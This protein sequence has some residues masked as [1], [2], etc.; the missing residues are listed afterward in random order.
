MMLRLQGNRISKI[1]KE[2]VTHSPGIRYLYLGENE[3]ASLER[4]AMAQFE[5]VQVLDLSYNRLSEVTTDTFS[6]LAHLLHL[7]LEGNVIKDVAPGAFSQTPLLLLWLASNCLSDVSPNMFQGAPF[8]RQISLSNNNIRIVQPMS[9]AHLA[10]LHTL[11]LA[12]NKLH[13]LQP[14]AITSTDHLT[15]RLQEN[16]FVCSQDGFHVMNGRTAINLTNEPNFICKTDYTRLSPDQCPTRKER[17]P[18]APCCSKTLPMGQE[19][20][21][22]S[23]VS[24]EMTPSIIEQTTPAS[25]SAQHAAA[26]RLNMQRFFKLSQTRRGEVTQKKPG[27]GLQ[28]GTGN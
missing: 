2:T 9:F 4:G 8:L 10:N 14:G 3:L 22:S 15:V 7:N 17:P 11:D 1:E 20:T 26:R 27:N 18:I 19:S 21:M 16:P 25:S 5:H 13:T 24:L 23:A 6:G 28:S 12:Y